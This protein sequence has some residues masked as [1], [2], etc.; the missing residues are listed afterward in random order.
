MR[1]PNAAVGKHHIY[2][3]NR[4]TLKKQEIAMGEMGLTSCKLKAHPIKF[5]IDEKK[6]PMM[7]CQFHYTNI[8]I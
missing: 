5:K 7:F 3:L 8:Q 2:Y 6:V 1:G 4:N